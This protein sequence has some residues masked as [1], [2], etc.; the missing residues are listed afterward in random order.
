[1]PTIKQQ[2]IPTSRTK[3]RPGYAMTPQYITIHSTGNPKSTAQNEANYVCYNSD[4]QASYHYVCDDSQIIQVLPVN[5][6]AWHAGDGGSGTGNRK[7][8]AIE[9]CE[10][11]DRKKAVDNAVWLTKEL[12]RDL[13]IDKA[14]IRQHHDWSGKDCPRI[15]RDSAYIKDGIDWSYFMAQIDAPQEQEEPE[16]T[17][18]ELEMMLEKYFE[19]VSKE[20]PGDWSKEARDWAEKNGIVTGDEGGKRYKSLIT[21]EEAV[22]MLYRSKNL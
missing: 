11:G 8:V 5:E 9:I 17:Q 10:P 6:V 19:K 22:T 14:H 1:M 16:L 18:E 13:K 2:F 3:Q 20:Q 12:M 21:R 4:R 15:L 7:S